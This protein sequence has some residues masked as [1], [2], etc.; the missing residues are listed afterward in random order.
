MSQSYKLKE[1]ADPVFVAPDEPLEARRKRIFDRKKAAAERAGKMVEVKD[2][3]LVV[4]GIEVYCVKN[5]VIR[6]SDDQ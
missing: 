6:H 5:G 3:V 1:Y 2:N 4:D